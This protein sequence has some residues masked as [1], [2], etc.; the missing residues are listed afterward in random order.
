I[1]RRRAAIR[2]RPYAG[3]R[4]NVA[5]A[6][7]KGAVFMELGVGIIGY[8]KQGAYHAWEVTRVEGLRL[9]AVCDVTPASREQ[10]LKDHPGVRVYDDV[11]RFLGDPD[12]QIV[13]IVTP[14]TTHAPYSI[15]SMKAGKHVV[16]E[17]P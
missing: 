7:S 14:T 1:L 9:A 17:K 12:V 13:V 11:Q 3:G 5:Q 6:E 4:R 10:A 2:R 8:G 16:C 15:E